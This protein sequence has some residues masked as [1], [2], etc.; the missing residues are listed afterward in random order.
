MEALYI[1]FYKYRGLVCLISGLSYCFVQKCM[2]YINNLIVM[3]PTTYIQIMC[4][5]KYKFLLFLPLHQSLTIHNKNTIITS[6]SSHC[7]NR[8][9]KITATKTNFSK[10]NHPRYCSLL[11]KPL[12]SIKYHTHTHTYTPFFLSLRGNNFHFSKHTR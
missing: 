8:K 7:E 1:F 5:F 2:Q 11:C 6:L 9:L 4:I 12:H 3:Y 10:I